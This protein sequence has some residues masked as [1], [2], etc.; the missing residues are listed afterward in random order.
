MGFTG[1]GLPVGH[2][3]VAWV[4]VGV[5]CGGCG[6]VCRVVAM[7]G[8]FGGGGGGGGDGDGLVVG[9]VV[10]FDGG[11]CFPSQVVFQWWR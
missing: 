5:G 10:L 3:V 8:G 9:L 6:F 7:S 1:Y 4:M 11:F 2:G